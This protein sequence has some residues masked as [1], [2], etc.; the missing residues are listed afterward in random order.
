MAS[1]HLSFA[2]RDVSPVSYAAQKAT[3]LRYRY[4]ELDDA[5]GMA[6]RLLDDGV[7]PWEIAGDDGLVLGRAEIEATVRR[8]ASELQD[9][10]KPL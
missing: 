1:Y 2:H 4:D 7:V 3:L 6:L 9:R 8:R 5:L 10:P